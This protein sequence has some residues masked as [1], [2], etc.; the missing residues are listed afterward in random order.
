MIS[1]LIHWLFEYVVPFSTNVCIFQFSFWYWCLTSSHCGQRRYFVQ[2][3]PF[4]T[5]VCWGGDVI[6]PTTV[7]HL[8]PGV[9][10]ICP[11]RSD[12]SSRPVSSHTCH[13]LSVDTVAP[14]QA[15][16]CDTAQLCFLYSTYHGAICP[17]CSHACFYSV[18]LRCEFLGAG[19]LLLR[20]VSAGTKAE[21]GTQEV[22]KISEGILFKERWFTFE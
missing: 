16:P 18:C 21:S 11:H 13:F 8:S 9:S 5:W 14:N 17:I 12:T 19:V 4:R 6:Y 7:T 1:S 10:L 3:L 20:A 15:T 2:H 22:I